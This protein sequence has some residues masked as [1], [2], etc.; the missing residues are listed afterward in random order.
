MWRSI[1]SKQSTEERGAGRFRLLFY[2]FDWQSLHRIEKFLGW[3]VGMAMHVVVDKRWANVNLVLSRNANL[4]V[5][6][7]HHLPVCAN[8]FLDHDIGGTAFSAPLITTHYI[9]GT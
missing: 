8:W 4:S 6:E 1:S 7:S 2:I 5:A 9:H 3:L